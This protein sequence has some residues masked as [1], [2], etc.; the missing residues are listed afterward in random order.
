MYEHVVIHVPCRKATYMHH[1]Y[2]ISSLFWVCRLIFTCITILATEL[3]TWHCLL[4]TCSSATLHMSWL[5]NVN[6]E[7][8]PHFFSLPFMTF[9]FNSFRWCFIHWYVRECASEVKVPAFGVHFRSGRGYSA[10]LLTMSAIF[11]WV[12]IQVWNLVNMW[13]VSGAT[14]MHGETFGSLCMVLGRLWVKGYI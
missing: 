12:G 2:S 9:I 13:K 7:V 10:E 8:I 5:H 3:G 1:F 4:D 11:N 6:M 14:N